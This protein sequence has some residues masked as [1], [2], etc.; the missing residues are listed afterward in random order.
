M[1]GQPE[2]VGYEIINSDFYVISCPFQMADQL[3][4]G[5]S[6]RLDQNFQQELKHRRS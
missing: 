1:L 6:M 3:N 4:T 2:I 5:D